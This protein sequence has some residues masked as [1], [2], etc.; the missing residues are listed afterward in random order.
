MK[1]NTDNNNFVIEKPLLFQKLDMKTS[2]NLEDINDNDFNISNSPYVTYINRNKSP[3]IKNQKQLNNIIYFMKTKY[4][5][6][7][8]NNGIYEGLSENQTSYTN[9]SN[10]ASSK[11]ISRKPKKIETRI[12]QTN[13]IK[14]LSKNDKPKKSVK[15]N[16]NFVTIIQVKSYKKY[17]IN[18]YYN[19][20]NS[21]N[22][23]CSI[24]QDAINKFL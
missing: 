1:I 16:S 12:S 4:I 10:P 8:L 24:F 23:S 6:V 17:N 14:H 13:Q 5:N 22:C 15:F 11:T 20:N 3:K 19:N 9:P 2:K 7:L 18:K 21:L